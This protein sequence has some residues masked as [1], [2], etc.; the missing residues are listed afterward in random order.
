[1]YTSFFE[2]KIKIK[3]DPLNVTLSNYQTRRRERGD[4]NFNEWHRRFVTLFHP[5][6]WFTKTIDGF[7]RKYSN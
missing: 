5:C 4:H 1:M 3:N 2:Y 6:H 7:N